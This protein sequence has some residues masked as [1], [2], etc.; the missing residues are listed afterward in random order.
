MA[1]CCWIFEE[2]DTV[3]SSAVSD[4]FESYVGIRTN[5]LTERERGISRLKQTKASGA[6]AATREALKLNPD[7]HLPKTVDDDLWHQFYDSMANF[8]SAILGPRLIQLLGLA[9]L[10]D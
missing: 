7:E 3:E 10:K 5:F 2:I 9:P 1:G 8:E 6:V 4:G